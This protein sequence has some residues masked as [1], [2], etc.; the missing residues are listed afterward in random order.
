LVDTLGVIQRKICFE[1]TA[2]IAQLRFIRVIA[3]PTQVPDSAVWPHQVL[4][5]NLNAESRRHR[6]KSPMPHVVAHLGTLGDIAP[7]TTHFL[8]RI[9]TNT[10]HCHFSKATR[11][12]RDVRG[13][14]AVYSPHFLRRIDADTADDESP[15]AIS[16][17]ELLFDASPVFRLSLMP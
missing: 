11:N 9:S 14:Y 3:M 12:T 8:S 5:S 2:S 13:V 10:R 16:K 7:N 1:S 6:L 4:G 15:L 17:A